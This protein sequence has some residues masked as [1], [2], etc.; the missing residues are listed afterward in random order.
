MTRRLPLIPTLV[1]V[2][3]CLTMI[4]LG[5]WQLRRAEE[6]EAL[7]ARYA[8]VQGQP[9]IAFPTI[10]IAE[11]DLPLFRRATGLC[12]RV[13]S[14]RTA[15]GENRRGET[16]FLHIADCG[17]GAEGPGMAVEMG[18]S[19]D[20]NA[21][22]AWAGGAV[23]GIIAPD[24]RSRMRLVSDTGLGGL[25]PSKPPSPETI[26]N[27]HRSYAVQWF[28]FALLAALI[29]FLAVRKRWRQEE[30]AQ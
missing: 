25:Q 14:R 30:E 7:L 26:P 1:V 27:N 22:R 29:Y 18:W 6:K 16:G 5:I 23:S 13:L 17:S 10:P 2:A 4:G 11:E 9:P 12:L 21:G 19:K 20:P 3:A 15:A 24:R 28:L 8:A